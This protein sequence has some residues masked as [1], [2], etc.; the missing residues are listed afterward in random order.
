MNKKQQ[1]YNCEYFKK[2]IIIFV[3]GAFLGLLIEETFL[4]FRGIIYDIDRINW[5]FE[6]SL[7]YGPFSPVYGI[8]AVVLTIFFA[9]KKLSW[10]KIFLL[11]SLLGGI[12][13]F[14]ASLIQENILGVV[15]WDYTDE[16][17]NILGRTKITYML[18]FGF[19][20]MAF[21]K[22]VYPLIK[23]F[24][25]KIPIIIKNILYYSLLVFMIFNIIISIMAINRYY[26]RVEGI[27]ASTSI[28]KFLDKYYHDEVVKMHVYKMKKMK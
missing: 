26:E 3:V 27:E 1:K 23:L 8:G 12:T 20:G 18:G 25:K 9:D 11:A 13:E 6:R 16:F 17:S 7:I 4:Y 21:I 2:L 19:I 22:G 15:S 5:N 10:W 24:L 14:L 28:D